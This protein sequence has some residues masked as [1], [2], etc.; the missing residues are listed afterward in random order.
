[1]VFLDEYDAKDKAWRFDG[2]TKAT[3]E[4]FQKCYTAQKQEYE[5]FEKRLKSYLKRY[6]TEKLKTWTYWADE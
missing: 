4:D 2:L 5:K 1:M 6:G 3:E